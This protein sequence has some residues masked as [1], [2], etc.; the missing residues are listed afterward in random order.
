MFDQ[1]HQGRDRALSP[2]RPTVDR[3][4]PKRALTDAL[5][6][7]EIEPAI[8]PDYVIVT[9]GTT[10]RLKL[11]RAELTALRDHAEVALVPTPHDELHRAL[12]MATRSLR[13]ILESE[14]GWVYS[15]DLVPDDLRT[16]YEL[17]DRVAAP[18]RR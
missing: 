8:D 13:T 14:P 9:V 18:N 12:L 1:I 5:R 15:C 16:L 3:V 2:R 10:P 6:E 17:F 4:T 11:H 7:V